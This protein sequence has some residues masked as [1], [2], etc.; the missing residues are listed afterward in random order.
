MHLLGVATSRAYSQL[1]DDFRMSILS[2]DE[3]R[4]SSGLQQQKKERKKIQK[5]AHIHKQM[6]TPRTHEHLQII[7]GM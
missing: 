6:A 2:G 3:E 5:I 4:R 1:F 7:M